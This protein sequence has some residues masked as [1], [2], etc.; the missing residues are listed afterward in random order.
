MVIRKIY[1]KNLHVTTQNYPELSTIARNYT[2]IFGIN[3]PGRL[4]SELS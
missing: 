2:L 4:R 3:F 1:T